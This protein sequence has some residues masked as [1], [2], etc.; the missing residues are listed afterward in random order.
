MITAHLSLLAV[1]KKGTS[2]YDRRERVK[3]RLDKMF[4]EGKDNEEAKRKKRQTLPDTTY[5]VQLYMVVDYYSYVKL[6]Q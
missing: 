2:E 3:A 6:V 5:I 1:P 4:K